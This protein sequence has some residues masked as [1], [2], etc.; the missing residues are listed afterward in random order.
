M[1]V[2]FE[3]FL[4]T[5]W[6]HPIAQVVTTYL[7]VVIFHQNTDLGQKH[8]KEIVLAIINYATRI[9]IA[10]ASKF[11]V[12]LWIWHIYD[13]LKKILNFKFYWLKEHLQC[14]CAKSWSLGFVELGSVM[15]PMKW[16][17][18]SLDLATNAKTKWVI[19]NFLEFNVQVCCFEHFQWKNGVLNSKTYILIQLFT[20]C[21]VIVQFCC[22]C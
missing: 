14:S 7:V 5:K 3:T 15:D 10:I 17:T 9:S 8:H 18:M 1:Y 11:L 13:L 20:T 19:C 21:K 16:S 4:T 2:E 6:F 12:R 22:C